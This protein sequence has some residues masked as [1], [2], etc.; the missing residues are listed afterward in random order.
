M[1]AKNIILHTILCV[2]CILQ[3]CT[4]KEEE[5]PLGPTTVEV[6][7]DSFDLGEIKQHK[8]RRVA[9]C[10]INTGIQA[11]Q[12]KNVLPSCE[13]TTAEVEKEITQPG[14]T[15]KVILIFDGKDIG[16]FYRTAEVECNMD[17]L[18]VLTITGHVTESNDTKYEKQYDAKQKKL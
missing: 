7:Q 6:K 10:L 9:F 16:P 12:I 8:K 13:C 2:T 3:A 1:N 18:V 4:H 5:K 14:D 11:L 17:S 15:A